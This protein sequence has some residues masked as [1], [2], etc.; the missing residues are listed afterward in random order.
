MG[1]MGAANI[2]T[3]ETRAAPLNANRDGVVDFGRRRHAG[4]E[5]LE[6][7]EGPRCHHLCEVTLCGDI[8]WARHGAPS[9]RGW[10]NAPWSGAW[11]TL[12]RAAKVG[13]IN[14][15]GGTS[16]TVGRMS[17]E[18]EAVRRVLAKAGTPPVSSTQVG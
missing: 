14:A 9:G 4:V 2:T 13:Y 1:A 18:I 8:R 5:E 7:A 3:P 10:R 16:H 17:G 6:H 12:P 15:H 11:K